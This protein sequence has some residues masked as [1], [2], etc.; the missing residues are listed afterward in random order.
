[1]YK[2]DSCRPTIKTMSSV[3]FR[4]AWGW[5]SAF[6]LANATFNCLVSGVCLL[7]VTRSQELQ[8]EWFG[9]QLAE[10][11]PPWFLAMFAGTFAAVAAVFTIGNVLVLR[12]PR[13][14]SWWAAHLINIVLG[15]GS[16]LLTVPCIF[17]FAVWIRPEVKAAFDPALPDP[18]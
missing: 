15:L 3:E 5:Y 13:T 16:G 17:L 1:M 6:C 11:L 7:A 8:T 4:K 18:A 9:E 12:A 14:K 10:S 2:P